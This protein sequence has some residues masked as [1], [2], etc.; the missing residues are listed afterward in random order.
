[1][2]ELYRTAARECGAQLLPAAWIFRVVRQPLPE[3]SC[4][5]G[6]SDSEALP[7]RGGGIESSPRFT[8]ARRA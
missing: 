1:M 2:G 5:P 6:L 7:Q 8:N 3:H 4:E